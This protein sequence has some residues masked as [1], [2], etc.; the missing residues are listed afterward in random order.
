MEVAFGHLLSIMGCPNLPRRC[1]GLP[2]PGWWNRGKQA[3]FDRFYSGTPV[4]VHD[5][6]PP[7][8]G[9]GEEVN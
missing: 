5:G 8:S 1:S 2:H 6:T 4:A 7:K 9:E 3:I